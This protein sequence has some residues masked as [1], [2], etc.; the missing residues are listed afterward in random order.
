[1]RCN[2]R[3]GGKRPRE[4]LAG[5]CISVVR[6]SRQGLFA[7]L[8]ERAFEI[9]VVHTDVGIVVKRENVAAVEMAREMVEK[10]DRSGIEFCSDRHTSQMLKCRCLE[11]DD[12]SQNELDCVLAVGGDGTIL[13]VARQVAKFCIPIYPGAISYFSNTI[14]TLPSVLM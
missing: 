3:C 8:C 12:M 6:V 2:S 7:L 4:P 9:G 1:M 5:W 10:F 11:F 14:T 13:S